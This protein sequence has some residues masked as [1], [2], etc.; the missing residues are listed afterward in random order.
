MSPEQFCYWLQGRAELEPSPP[1]P[2]QWQSI[3]EHLDLVFHKVTPPL[4]LNPAEGRV[5]DV[6]ADMERRRR[7]RRARCGSESILLC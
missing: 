3:R 2:E 4:E 6:I 5:V 1:T 7:I